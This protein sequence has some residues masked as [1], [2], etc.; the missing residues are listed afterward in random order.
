MFDKFNRNY[1]IGIIT[2]T[3]TTWN[4][5]V[6]LFLFLLE[7]LFDCRQLQKVYIDSNF[8][9]SNYLLNKTNLKLYIYME[10]YLKI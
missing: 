4:N 7:S 9:C 6:P 1:W 8:A 5:F 2:Q 10:S 3:D